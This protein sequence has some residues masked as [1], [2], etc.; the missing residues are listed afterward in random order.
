MQKIARYLHGSQAEP[1]IEMPHYARIQPGIYS[2]YCRHSCIYYDRCYKRWVCLLRFDI[3]AADNIT[4]LGSP[5]MFLNLGS[6]KKPRASLR[7]RFLVELKKADAEAEA[8]RHDRLTARVFRG[9]M[10]TIRIA[11]T[12]EKRSAALYSV[13]TE[14]LSWDTGKSASTNQ[15]IMQSREAPPKPLPLN[16]LQRML[17][18]K[19]PFSTASALAGVESTAV[20]LNQCSR[21]GDGEPVPRNST[22]DA[23]HDS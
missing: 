16:T 17:G 13:V 12:D 3:F 4:V 15:S 6:G 9:R 5:C 2:S 22:G 1:E 14:I 21:A 20:Q 8:R 18:R 10:A 11:D 23:Q 19:T 7:G